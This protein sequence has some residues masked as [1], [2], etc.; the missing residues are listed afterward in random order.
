L[1]RAISDNPAPHDDS[2]SSRG[3]AAFAPPRSPGAG[4]G[5][6]RIDWKRVARELDERGY[7]LAADLLDA[8]QCAALIA[9]YGDRARFRSR[10]VM[11]RHRYGVGEYK[12]FSYPLPAIVARIR[13]ALYRGMAPVA[14]AWER[15]LG[16]T[17]VYPATLKEFLA[18]CHAA[19]QARPTPLLLRYQKGGYNCLH[20]DLYG[21]IAFP[22]QLTCMLSRPGLD[23]EGGEFLLVEQRPR[24]Q[25]RGYAIAL[26]RG[27]AIIFPNRFRPVTGARGDSRVALRHGVST[28]TRGERWTLGAILHDAE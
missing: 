5:I 27:C 17:S 19:G 11:E 12:Y 8:E 16:G 9:L 13:T 21:Q 23:F 18:R 6:A 7:A 28:V 26:D 14:N 25:S 2:R 15:R 24:A 4:G 1:T 10:V 20:Q 3:A 22:F